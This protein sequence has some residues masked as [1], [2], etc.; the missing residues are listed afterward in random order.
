MTNLQKERSSITTLT[1]E[2]FSVY[3]IN[4]Q[5]HNLTKPKTRLIVEMLAFAN[6]I[7]PMADRENRG[8][9]RCMEALQTME[10]KTVV[11]AEKW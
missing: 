8:K 10:K 6:F 5:V 7:W 1:N 3:S 9:Q 2:V 4:P 11:S